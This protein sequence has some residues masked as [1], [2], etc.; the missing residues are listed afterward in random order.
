MYVCNDVYQNFF[1]DGLPL[2][3][4]YGNDGSAE[5]EILSKKRFYR[6]KESVNQVSEYWLVTKKHK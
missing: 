1:L 5:N 2:M 4:L 6:K 3:T